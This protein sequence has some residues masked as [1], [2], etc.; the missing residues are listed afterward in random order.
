MKADPA[1]PPAPR[2]L[3]SIGAFS[4]SRHVVEADR[5]AVAT[6]VAIG[7]VC[8]DFRIAA[9]PRLR[10]C[11][12]SSHWQPTYCGEIRGSGDAPLA[13]RRLGSIG[14]SRGRPSHDGASSTLAEAS[15]TIGFDRRRFEASPAVP[16]GRIPAP[17]GDGRL[18]SIGA[19]SS[20]WGRLSGFA[21]AGL[22][23]VDQVGLPKIRAHCLLV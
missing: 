17:R 16:S 1:P 5:H 4:A 13:P 15:S 14:A 18:G 12:L 3:G 8:R 20:A 7:F 21:Q 22:A 9:P 2:R 19:F 23:A 6:F 11:V 10:R